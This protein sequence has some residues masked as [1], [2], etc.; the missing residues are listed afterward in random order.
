MCQSFYN[1]K[2]NKPLMKELKREKMITK[3]ITP[4]L[5]NLPQIIGSIRFFNMSL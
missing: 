2:E 4:K 3:C 1:A 5:Y